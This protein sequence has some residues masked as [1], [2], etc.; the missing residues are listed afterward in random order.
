M[1]FHLIVTEQ[2]EEDLIRIGD[3][4][5][6]RSPDG[7]ARWL[8][9]ARKTIRSLREGA[10]GCSLAPENEFVSQEVRSTVFK[11]RRGRYY[12]IVFIINGDRVIVTH[13][14]GP[15]QADVSPEDFDRK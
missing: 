10:R 5:A 15:G 4:I 11:T 8:E 13:I 3:W 9:A 14:R 12:R 7:A 6:E 2:A 1:T